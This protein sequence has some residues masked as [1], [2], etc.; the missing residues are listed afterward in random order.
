MF[1]CWL[2]VSAQAQ[3]C[4]WVPEPPK[5]VSSRHLPEFVF[6]QLAVGLVHPGLRAGAVAGIQVDQGAVGRARAGDVQAVAQ[7][8]QGAVAVHGPALRVGPVA[9]VDLDRVEVGG[10]GRAVVQAQAL[11]PGDR[12]GAPVAAAAAA[13]AARR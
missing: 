8:R 13:A 4:T 10:A 1:H 3:I 7:D 9:G 2:E 6:T 12:P 11:V 5:P